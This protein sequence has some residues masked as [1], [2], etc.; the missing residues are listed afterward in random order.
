M[1]GIFFL[2]PLLFMIAFAVFWLWML[3]HCLKGNSESKVAWTIVILVIPGLGAIL[4]RL[5]EYP[6]SN[7][8]RAAKA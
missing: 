6:K 4:Y 3:V 5:I 1:E 8:R 7:K 2:A